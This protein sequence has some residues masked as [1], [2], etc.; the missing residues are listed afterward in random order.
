MLNSAVKELLFDFLQCS[1]TY[2]WINQEADQRLAGA[3]SGERIVEEDWKPI[4]VIRSLADPEI[5]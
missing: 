5:S 3:Q 4:M 1:A 2:K